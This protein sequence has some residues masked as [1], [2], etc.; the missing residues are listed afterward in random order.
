MARFTVR[1]AGAEPQAVEVDGTRITVGAIEMDIARAAPGVYR[2]SDGDRVRTLWVAGPADARW[3]FA[4]G[5]VYVLE[6]APEG[7]RR[8]RAGAGDEALTAPM[9]ATVVNVLV[10]PGQPVK[11]GDVLL[12]LEAMKM[13]LPVKAPRDGIVTTLKC[14]RGELVL[15]GVALIE[16]E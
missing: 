1:G 15:P 7:S 6:V 5:R 10:E 16:L 3:V 12:M 8:R 14:S 9:P 13:E 2:V 11:A 4:D